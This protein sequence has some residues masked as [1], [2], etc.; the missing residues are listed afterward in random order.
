[1]LENSCYREPLRTFYSGGYEL[2]EADAIAGSTWF[3]GYAL[4]NNTYIF[5][6]SCLSHIIMAWVSKT[7]IILLIKNE[8][9]EKFYL[10]F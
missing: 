4:Y 8:A 7:R 9:M 2:T 3:Q 1:M 5:F 10:N 6:D